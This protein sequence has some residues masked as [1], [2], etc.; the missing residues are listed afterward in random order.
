MS[1]E[2]ITRLPEDAL[3]LLAFWKEARGKLALPHISCLDPLRLWRWLGNLSMM[4]VHQGD[5]RFYIR[6][7]GTITSENIGQDFSRRY[8]EDCAP[9]HAREL[10]LKP[11]TTCV[12]TLMPTYS[13]MVPGLI[14][15]VFS[16]FERLALPF[17]ASEPD[18]E[19]QPVGAD[20][21]L[22]WVSLTDADTFFGPTVYGEEEPT[23]YE[24]ARARDAAALTTIDVDDPAYLLFEE[25]QSKAPRAAARPLAK[26]A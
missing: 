8:L 20:R 9:P 17:T 13:V 7:H 11:Y 14:S 4:D 26:Q 15:G 3:D 24:R 18:N 21:L 23:E 10:A 12:E 22:V 16:R 19:I 2:T 1:G 6:L 25:N 5:K